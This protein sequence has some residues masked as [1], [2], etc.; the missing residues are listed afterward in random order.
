MTQYLKLQE[1]DI[2]EILREYDIE[3][4]KVMICNPNSNYEAGVWGIDL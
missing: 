4:S 3:L 1:N 2:C